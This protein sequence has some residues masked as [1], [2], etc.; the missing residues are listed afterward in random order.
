MPSLKHSKPDRLI[1]IGCSTGGP[2]H[3]H[4]IVKSLTHDF[5][6]TLI[7]AQHI[8]NKF[9]PSF[10]SQLNKESK[11]EVLR[12]NDKIPILRGK[13][14]VCSNVSRLKNVNSHLILE[15]TTNIAKGYNPD[16]NILFSSAAKLADCYHMLG[17]IMTGIGD[18]GA[19]GIKELAQKG[20]SCI[21]ESESSAIVYGMPLQAKLR[22]KDINQ[23]HLDDII[24]SINR[25]G[26]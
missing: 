8:T 25:F 2:G 23:K 16:I 11:I 20:A 17:I 7:I 10:I 14:Y 3:L 9:I 1:L 15:Q 5:S 21:A 18:D 6:A 12:G 26:R 13:I 19:Q 4:K 22:V 24:T